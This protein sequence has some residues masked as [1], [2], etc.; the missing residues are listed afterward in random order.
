MYH[1]ERQVPGHG[2]AKIMTTFNISK[3]RLAELRK[4]F[5][6]IT[7]DELRNKANQNDY[8]TERGLMNFFAKRNSDYQ[9]RASRKDVKRI[10]I[11]MT[12][13]KSVYGY[14]PRADMRVNY[15]DGHNEYFEN[16]A[17]AGGWGY[18][19]ASTVMAECLDLVCS[20]MLWKRRKPRKIPY[21]ISIKNTYFPHF[22]GGIGV[23]CYRD[24]AEFL[25]GKMEHVANSK[26]YDKYVFTF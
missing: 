4:Q 3:S 10:E 5:P 15:A 24:I 9:E 18:D 19:K 25:G 16:C 14:C 17:Y 1:V 6:Y 22:E 7:A 20:G 11:E 8:K 13:R 26:T 21:G 12:W 23:D 2:G